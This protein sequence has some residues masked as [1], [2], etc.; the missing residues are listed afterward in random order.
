MFA[1][2]DKVVHSDYGICRVVRMG[3]R[4]FP[5]QETRDYYE[6]TPLADDGYGTTFF[7]AVDHGG[8]LREPLSRE[9]ILEMIDAMPDI[10]PV[11]IESC[12][13]RTQDMENIKTEYTR[14][15]RSG[16]PKDLVVLLRTIYRKS[17][18]LSEQHKRIPEFE[19][20]ARENSERLLYGEIS[21]VMGIPVNRVEQFISDRI[22]N[23]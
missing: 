23:K 20:Y 22:G 7:T 9:Q 12:G 4:R 15:M 10:D 18:K 16:N 1:V 3:P 19:A 17:R 6:I 2:G 11:K 8:K 13:N 14:L 5:G 21:G